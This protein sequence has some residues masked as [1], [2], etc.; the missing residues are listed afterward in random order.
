MVAALDKSV[1]KAEKSSARAAK[2]TQQAWSKAGQGFAGMVSSVVPGAGMFS[3]AI[4]S[5][6]S[7]ASGMG[8]EMAALAGPLAIGAAALVAVSAAAFGVANSTSAYVDK[9]GL[10]AAKTGLASD[11]IIALEAALKAGGSSLE[12]SQMGL[13]SFV[14]KAADAATK[15]GEAADAFK[16]LG[17]DVADSTGHLRSSDDVL[18]DTLDAIGRLPTPTDQAAASLELFGTRGGAIVGALG[19]SSDSLDRWSQTAHEAGLVIDDELIAGSAAMDA[20]LASL[21]ISVRS[22]TNSLGREAMPAVASV[23]EVLA[24]VVLAG[25]DAFLIFDAITDRLKRMSPHWWAV[26]GAIAVF[27]DE[28]ED[29]AASTVQ[30]TGELD[31]LEDSV[32]DLGAAMAGLRTAEDFLAIQNELMLSA[33]GA[34]TAQIRLARTYDEIDEK[35][36]AYIAT[37]REEGPL[38]AE[39]EAR[40][41]A[42]AEAAKAAAAAAAKATT[43]T[44]TQ[45]GA[46]KELASAL[47]DIAAVQASA[48]SDVEV[49][50]VA[51]RMAEIDAVDALAASHSDSAEV[52]AAAAAA[53][54][55]IVER[56]E[57]DSDAVLDAELERIAIL[58]EARDV[59]MAKLEASVVDAQAL[60]ER[61]MRAA[62]D[63]QTELITSMAE[64]ASSLAGGLASG[65]S[66][67]AGALAESGQLGAKAALRAYRVS[68]AAALTS[69]A[70][71]TSS[72]AIK[73]LAQLGPI[74]GAIAAAAVTATGIG[75]AIKVANTPPPAFYSGGYLTPDSAVV[76]NGEVIAGSGAVQTAASVRR[77]DPADLRARNSGRRSPEA[78]QI[79]M[80]FGGRVLDHALVEDS[81]RP[82]S[83]LRTTIGTGIL[84]QRR[85]S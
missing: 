23:V 20:S 54:I 77:G 71:D 34:S 42:T 83:A 30:L 79:N 75:A 31:R 44:R 76:H 6:A 25:R 40:L 3:G 45:A 21:D 13:A 72:A 33:T 41:W 62:H 4:S 9:I 56:G 82:G 65:I 59:A 47:R 58:S 32:V 39:R 51:A 7:A 5:A 12:A 63:A 53:K 43:S 24:D 36:T 37:L 26:Q 61:V 84:G 2:A 66:D 35:T 19:A 85:R 49:D 50:A 14:K 46:G 29:A 69:I 38:S 11:S 1:K 18:R 60:S 68:Q 78:I 16:R 73:A 55:A 80:S 70:I 10:A 74:A 15:G 52:Q 48:S 67:L 8:A 27:G 57:R 17:V 64:T 22:L 81:K 28:E